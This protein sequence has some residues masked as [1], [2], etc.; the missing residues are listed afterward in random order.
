MTHT[1]VG[2]AIDTEK[3]LK[4]DEPEFCQRPMIDDIVQTDDAVYRVGGGYGYRPMHLYWI[5]QRAEND[6]ALIDIELAEQRVVR[7]TARDGLELNDWQGYFLNLLAP[8]VT[9]S[10]TEDT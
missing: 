7:W 2:K 10:P 5:N 4:L 8:I 6:P 9:F 1:I 3:W